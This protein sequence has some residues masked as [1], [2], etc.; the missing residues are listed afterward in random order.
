MVVVV[1]RGRRPVVAGACC[2]M[3]AAVL[4]ALSAPISILK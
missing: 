4:L 2:N 3:S 1:F